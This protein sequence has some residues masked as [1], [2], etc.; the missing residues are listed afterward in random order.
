MTLNRTT[1]V[2]LAAV[3]G[4]GVAGSASAQTKVMGLNAEGS[5]EAGGIWYLTD[6]PG[7]KE[8]A[9]FEEY[10]D[11]GSG[12]ALPKFKLYGASADGQANHPKT[13]AARTMLRLSADVALSLTPRTMIV[14]ALRKAARGSNRKPRAAG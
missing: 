13:R 12:L 14:S 10:R 3:L 9:K 5:V 7:N 1:G 6:E 2:L 4:L 11:L 8:R